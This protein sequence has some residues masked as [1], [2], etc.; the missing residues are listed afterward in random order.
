MPKKL[1]PTGRRGRPS[2]EESKARQAQ[3]LALARHIFIRR[4]YRA[5]KMEEIAAAAG[6]TKRTLYVWHKDKQSLF[7]E[8]I[9]FGARRFPSVS[10]DDGVDVR[11]ALVQYAIALHEEL[12]KEDSSGIGLLFIRE[13]PEFPELAEMVQQPHHDYLLLPLSKFLEKHGMEA[14][15]RT[16]M[17]ALFINMALSPLHNQMMLDIALPSPQAIQRHAE[18]CADL[19]CAKA[20]LAAMSGKVT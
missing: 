6:I 1:M 5:T 12:A 2:A 15:G 17:A 13:G 9:L 11:T 19:F 20:Q 14:E 7:R 4:G 3:L 18:I 16:E 8:C 10:P